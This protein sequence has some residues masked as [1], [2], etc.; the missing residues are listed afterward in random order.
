MGRQQLLCRF[1]CDK[2]KYPWEKTLQ[3]V[4]KPLII[5]YITI[6]VQHDLFVDFGVL[7][8]MNFSSLE[9]WDH[10]CYINDS[11]LQKGSLHLTHLTWASC[12]C[13]KMNGAKRI[14][15][16]ENSPTRWVKGGFIVLDDLGDWNFC[17]VWLFF[18]H[19]VYCRKVCVCV[20]LFHL[21]QTVWN[22][23]WDLFEMGSILDYESNPQNQVHKF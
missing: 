5:Q 11:Q 15:K 16:G 1:C 19:L 4:Y 6:I 2:R 21:F 9:S 10:L 12:A 8:L 17:M 18:V 14:C 22:E 20:C 3:T 13:A 23:R 7:C